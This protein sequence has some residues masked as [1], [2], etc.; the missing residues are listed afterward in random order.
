MVAKC[1]YLP[2][3]PARACTFF[4]YETAVVNAGDLDIGEFVE[5]ALR[6]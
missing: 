4:R 2:L 1:L 5:V 6:R 3:Q